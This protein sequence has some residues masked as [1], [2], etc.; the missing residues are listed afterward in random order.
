MEILIDELSLQA[1]DAAQVEAVVLFVPRDQRPLLGLSG[2][3][4]WRLN[5]ALS[6]T[7]Q[8]GFFAGHRG[9]TLLTPSQGRLPAP[10]LLLFGL[11]DSPVPA[12]VSAAAWEK[13][14]VTL[15]L[16]RVRS[17]ALGAPWPGLTVEESLELWA[18]SLGGAPQRQWWL[19]D[20]RS[21]QRWHD[22]PGRSL[23]ARWSA[24]R[25]DPVGPPSRDAPRSGGRPRVPRAAG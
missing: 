19:G 4:D 18:K 6:R 3:C 20:L 5:G 10:R 8:Q 21:L 9:E 25:E 15:E 16:A 12:S 7:L 22:G 2:L 1:V 17:I 11:G 24:A 14:K 13:A 23:E